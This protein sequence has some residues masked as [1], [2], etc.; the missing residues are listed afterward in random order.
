M[1]DAMDGVESGN[2]RIAKPK[3]RKPL[4]KPTKKRKST[5][6]IR[7]TVSSSAASLNATPSKKARISSAVT[8][9]EEPENWATVGHTTH[10]SLPIVH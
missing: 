8:V 10:E 1:G 3:S 9:T 7:S 4:P 5:G 2:R 6:A